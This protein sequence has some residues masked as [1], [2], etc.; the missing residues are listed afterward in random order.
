MIRYNISDQRFEYLHV[1]LETSA[2]P[3]AIVRHTVETSHKYSVQ[4]HC[5]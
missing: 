5:F 1:I 3:D 4:S 2:E